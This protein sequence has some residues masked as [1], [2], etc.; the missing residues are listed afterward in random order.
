MNCLTSFKEQILKSRRI[1]KY[2]P[3]GQKK[4]P[5]KEYYETKVEVVPLL[6]TIFSITYTSEKTLIICVICLPCPEFSWKISV[7]IL[8][9]LLRK[10]Y[11]NS[12]LRMFKDSENLKEI[13]CFRISTCN[14]AEILGL[15]HPQ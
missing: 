3:E 15:L 4:L 1:K 11:G 14:L 5:L 2:T 9:P 8:Q 7:K 6:K 10:G 12:T 13:P